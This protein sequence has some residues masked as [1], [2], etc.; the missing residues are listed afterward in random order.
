MRSC[1][2][3]RSKQT[4][5]GVWVALMSTGLLVSMISGCMPQAPPLDGMLPFKE[6][7]ELLF[8]MHANHGARYTADHVWNGKPFKANWE[9][10][11]YMK[12]AA[13]LQIKPPTATFDEVDLYMALE[14]ALAD[15]TFNPWHNVADDTILQ[16]FCQA[17]KNTESNM[18]Y[19]SCPD[20]PYDITIKVKN[21]TS[22]WFCEVRV[23]NIQDPKKLEEAAK[24]AQE[25]LDNLERQ[26]AND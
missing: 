25:K 19:G 16:C 15:Q 24:A 1:V 6:A 7:N 13:Q 4:R 2:P 23:Q 18:A 8:E 17:I 3:M 26:H 14:T 21:N 9:L 22:E 12:K 11:N 20:A 10:A 5:F